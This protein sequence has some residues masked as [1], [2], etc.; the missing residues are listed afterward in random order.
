[1][2][3]WSSLSTKVRQSAR[4]LESGGGGTACVSMCVDPEGGSGVASRAPGCYGARRREHALDGPRS[5][6]ER[7]EGVG[8]DGHRDSGNTAEDGAR[9]EQSCGARLAHGRA[10]TTGSAKTKTGCRLRTVRHLQGPY[11][12]PHISCFG[13]LYGGLVSMATPN[14]GSILCRRVLD[15]AGTQ[16]CIEAGRGCQKEGCWRHG[17]RRHGVLQGAWA[18]ADDGV[19]RGRPRHNVRGVVRP[20]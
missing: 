9:A 11:P 4:W 12:G 18:A 10:F 8:G 17:S 19:R 20:A 15:Q 16:F 13:S 3:A 2:R 5:G 6:G 7:R 1:M 14:I